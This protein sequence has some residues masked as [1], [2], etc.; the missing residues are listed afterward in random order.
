ME[1]EERGERVWGG[2]QKTIKRLRGK[3]F[4][5]IK[6]KLYSRQGKTAAQVS[7]E[8]AAAFSFTEKEFLSLSLSLPCS[9]PKVFKEEIRA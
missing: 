8:A 5:S 4:T 2:G 6:H 7:D 3:T 1:G 9:L